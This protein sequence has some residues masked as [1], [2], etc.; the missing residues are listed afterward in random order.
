MK[1]ILLALTFLAVGAGVFHSARQHASQ[2]QQ[3]V[4]AANESWQIHTQQLAVS[5]S[6]KIALTEHVRELK[7][8]AVRVQPMTGSAL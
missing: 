6:E 7:Q 2:L 4:Q 5:Q 1:K 3:K 8:T